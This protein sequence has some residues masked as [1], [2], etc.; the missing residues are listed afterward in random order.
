MTVITQ[1]LTSNGKDAYKAVFISGKAFDAL[2]ASVRLD[3]RFKDIEADSVALEIVSA[4]GLEEYLS[5]AANG[6]GTTLAIVAAADAETTLAMAKRLRMHPDFDRVRLYLASA[7]GVIENNEWMALDIEDILPASELTSEQTIGAV[8]DR[9]VHAWLAIGDNPLIPKFYLDSTFNEV[10]DWFE[11]TRWAWT[12]IDLSQIDRSLLAETELEV[13]KE[14][15]ILE[16]GTLPGAHNFLR[17]W[18]DEYSFSSWALSWGAEEARHSLVQSRYLRTLGIETMSKHAM[19]KRKP[20]P[21]GHNRASTLM[22]NIISEC[23]AA[24]YYRTLSAMTQEPVLKKIWK[25]LGRDESR[26]ARAFVIFCNELC[27]LDRENLVAA[28]EMAYV[29]LADRQGG[30]KHPAGHFY[31]HSTSTKGLRMAEAYLQ[32]TNQESITDRADN[33]VFAIL[34]S[35]TGDP[36]IT[37]VGA[38]RRK[39]RECM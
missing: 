27:A 1:Q 7:N 5:N 8:V 13:L 39:L 21:S 19:Y 33:R 24:E 23:R 26:H 15:A 18:S 22:M 9:G 12:D 25:L 6:H 38:I 32:E 4:D 20:Y 28:L 36:T 10:F 17:E 29:Y 16:F 14:S 35:I 11:N 34:R 2:P 37:N 30:V 31:S 3:Q